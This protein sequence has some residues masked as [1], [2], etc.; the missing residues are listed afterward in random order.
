[1]A[2]FLSAKQRDSFQQTVTNAT[3]RQQRPNE[4]NEKEKRE[5][6]VRITTEKKRPKK[7]T[8]RTCERERERRKTSTYVIVKHCRNVICWEAIGWKAHEHA[9]LSNSTC[10]WIKQPQKTGQNSNQA[11]ATTTNTVIASRVS[12]LGCLQKIKWRL[13]DKIQIGAGRDEAAIGR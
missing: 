5:T 6:N 3:I 10:R 8:E 4:E 12:P 1:M 2:V 13:W 9:C 7:K 11:E